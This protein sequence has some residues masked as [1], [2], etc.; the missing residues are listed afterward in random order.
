[1]TI[2]KQM[3]KAKEMPSIPSMGEDNFFIGECLCRTQPTFRDESI[4]RVRA[5]EAFRSANHAGVSMTVEDLNTQE[6]W[7]RILISLEGLEV[8]IKAMMSR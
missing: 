4:A 1:M 5:T 8:P 2:R 6:K 3:K 7:E